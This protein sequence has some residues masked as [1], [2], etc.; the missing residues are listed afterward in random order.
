MVKSM[1]IA[2]NGTSAVEK[3]C[4]CQINFSISVAKYRSRYGQAVV[5][6]IT[7]CCC[8]AQVAIKRTLRDEDL[9]SITCHRDRGGLTHPCRSPRIHCCAAKNTKIA[10]ETI[11]GRDKYC[12]TNIP[13]PSEPARAVVWAE[14]GLSKIWYCDRI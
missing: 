3:T 5:H 10:S 4:K 13:L 6:S 11:D 2:R 12:W 7:A 14:S 8:I 9:R 1:T